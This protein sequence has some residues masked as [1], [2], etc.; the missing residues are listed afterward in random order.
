MKGAVVREDKATTDLSRRFLR[1][2][3]FSKQFYHT[4]IDNQL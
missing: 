3:L 1:N 4:K 2:Y